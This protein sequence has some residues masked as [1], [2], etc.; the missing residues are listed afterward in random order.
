MLHINL[1]IYE[2]KKGVQKDEGGWGATPPKPITLSK[3][4]APNLH[5]NA[6]EG[7]NPPSPKIFFADLH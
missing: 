6:L 3:F 4:E 2:T 7:P 1:C 5:Q